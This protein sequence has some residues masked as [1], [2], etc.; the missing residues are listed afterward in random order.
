ME[1]MTLY[2]LEQKIKMAREAGADD[3]TPVELSIRTYNGDG[4]IGA[5]LDN[6]T[7]DRNCGRRYI[8]LEGR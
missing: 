5:G 4:H 1:S 7:L 6:A 2:E 3:N 8:K